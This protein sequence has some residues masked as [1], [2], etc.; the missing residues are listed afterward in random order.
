MTTPLV[1]PDGRCLQAKGSSLSI[2][3]V[4]VRFRQGGERLQG[5][6]LSHDL[7]KLLQSAAVPPWER[8]RLPLVFAGAE[9]LAVAGTTLR[10]P[11]W[12]ADLRL[13]IHRQ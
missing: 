9:L 1:L 7:K 12:P 5:H 2:A 8:Q 6:G 13:I 3:P 10:A 4:T 11:A